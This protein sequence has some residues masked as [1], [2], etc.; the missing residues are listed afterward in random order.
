MLNAPS[1][2]LKVCKSRIK[3]YSFD[4][5]LSKVEDAM[6]TDNGPIKGMPFPEDD[7]W[8]KLVLEFQKP[9]FWRAAWQIVNT[10]VPFALLWYFMYL[11]LSVS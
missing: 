3:D 1:A 5:T 11:S 2:A 6:T 4:Y 8:K 9:S 7:S 10:F